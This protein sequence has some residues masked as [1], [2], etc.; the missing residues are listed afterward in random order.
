M[1][2]CVRG[3]VWVGVGGCGWVVEYGC[4]CACERERDRE[5]EREREIAP[6]LEGSSCLARATSRAVASTCD[7]YAFGKSTCRTVWRVGGRV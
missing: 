3:R 1:C 5:I 6:S 2:V 4:M 7:E